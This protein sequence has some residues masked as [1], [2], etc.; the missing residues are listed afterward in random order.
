[1]NETIFLLLGALAIVGIGSVV[2]DNDDAHPPEV[3]DDKWTGDEDRNVIEG[4]EEAETLTGTPGD[5][6][7]YGEGG[8]DTVSA[9]DGDDKVITYDGDDLVDTGNGDDGV[10]TGWG[11]DT[12]SAGAGNDL[13]Y[14]GGDADQYGAANPGVNEGDDTIYG[15]SGDDVIITNGGNH[16]IYG[17]GFS[18]TNDDGDELYGHDRIEDHGGVVMIDAGEGD[19]VIWSPDD[20]TADAPDTLLGGNGNDTIYAGGFDLVDAGSGDDLIVLRSDAVGAADITWGSS[21]RYQISLTP[22][23]DGEEE[24]DLVQEGE[25]VHLI[26]DGNTLAVLRNVQV[27]DMRN[28]S[29]VRETTDA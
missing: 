22:G 16:V 21:D 7:I 8:N 13:V 28:I 6:A 18:D 3:P 11:R 26:V 25:D 10:W 12:V 20:S 29:F 27:N 2:S 15:G 19:D 23:Y 24:Y 5:D 9:G 4:T 14:L 17:D 1:M